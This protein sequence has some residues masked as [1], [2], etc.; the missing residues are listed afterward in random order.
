MERNID[1]NTKN[2]KKFDFTTI[3][4]FED[5]CRKLGI[6]PIKWNQEHD[7]LPDHITALMELQIITEAI[8]DGWSHPLTGRA[9]VSSVW[10]WLFD[11]DEIK[12]G[13]PQEYSIVFRMLRPDGTAGL[14]SARS[15]SGWSYS[16][17]YFGSRLAYQTKEQCDYSLKQFSSLW[18]SWLYPQEWQIE[19]RRRHQND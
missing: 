19:E 1:S 16:S 18:E 12:A 14:G 6:D 15:G 17:S 4:T 10:T 7:R 3:K 2:M 13:R 11:D 5:A 8:N 9:P